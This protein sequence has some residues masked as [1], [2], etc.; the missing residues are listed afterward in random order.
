MRI[1]SA[2]LISYDLS[3]SKETL[4]KHALALS[5]DERVELIDDLLKSVVDPKG[6]PEL[7][8][9]QQAELIRRLE[10]DRVDPSAEIPWEDAEKQI[11]GN[12]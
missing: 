11:T 7:S 3:M 12:Q 5:P 1:E 10:A 9:A 8:P 4:F 6:C 2:R